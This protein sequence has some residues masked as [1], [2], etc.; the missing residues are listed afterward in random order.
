MAAKPEELARERIDGALAQAG[1]V[2]QDADA[3]NLSAGLGIAV[4]E[5]PL[6]RGHG[7]ADYLLYVD[8][9]AAGV[10]EAKAEG[11]TLTGVEVQSEKYATGMPKELPAHLRP[12]P[13]LYQS[14][15]VE[16]CFTNRLDPEPRSR[17]VFHFHRPETLASWLKADSLWLPTKKG[18]PD[19]RSNLPATL[20]L[21]RQEMPPVEEKGLWSVQLRALRNLEASLAKDKP[22]SL[23]Q[24]A[25][26]SGKTFT[27]VSSIYRHIKFGGAN[28]VLFLVD[29]ANLGRQAAGRA[30][31]HLSL[32]A[33]RAIFVAG[34]QR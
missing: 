6:V 2:V 5:F 18:Q 29:R 21:R 11:T 24:M 12:L 16:T 23:I 4:R 1:W 15:G 30:S 22:R 32:S 27:A 9:K 33:T 19:P 14:T 25:T 20:R 17:R 28:H 13:F 7:H 31:S 34:G 8:G 26:G 10:I 3:I